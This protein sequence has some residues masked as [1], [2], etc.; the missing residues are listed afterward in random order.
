MALVD[1][2][3]YVDSV[4]WSAVTAW[5]A[6][7]TYDAGTLR[8][9]LAAPAV[10]SERIFV[11]VVGHVASGAAEPTWVI[12]RGGKTTD[13]TITW[14]EATGIAALNGDFSANTPTWATV[15]NTVVTLGQVI[16]DVA[17]SIVL[18]CTTAGTA[19]NGAEPTWAAYTTAG[20][21]TAD[22]TVTWTNIG[23]VGNFTG[24]QAPHARLASAFAATWG[25]V[26]NT[27]FV[28][29]EHAETRTT[30]MTLTS[31]GI[32]TNP[33]FV[34]CVAKT[35]I[36]P[37]AATTGATINTTGASNITFGAQALYAVGVT[38]SA[39][40]V[41]S[42]ASII[43][44]SADQ[45]Y[46]SFKTCGL[47][48]NNTSA[49]SR[50]YL[51][52][53]SFLAA[54]RFYFDACTFTFGSN[55]GQQ[56][57]ADQPLNDL[58]IRGG[59]VVVGANVPTTLFNG[60]ATN[61]LLEG[62]DLSA[63][64]SG[65]T[66]IGASIN[67]GHFEIKDCK[68]ATGVT[69]S[70]APLITQFNYLIRADDTGT[71]YRHELR[72]YP[73]TQTVDTTIVRTGGA[74]DGTTPISWKIITTANSKWVL[75]FESYPISLW[76]DAVAGPVTVTIYGTTT[77]GGVP[78]DD[79]IWMEIECLGTSGNPLGVF[80]TTTK[81]SVLVASSA[82]NNSADASTWGGGGAGNGFKI[83]GT[84]TPVLKGP[85]TVYVKAALASTTYYIDPRPAIS[86]VT[87]SKSEIL[88][89]GVYTNELSSQGP[90]GQQ[91][92]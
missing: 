90:V 10:G 13:A 65:K 36:P 24:W 58:V 88:A 26:G 57:L 83:V 32:F 60:S 54:S 34:V 41:A 73:G 9:Q 18:I 62:F 19:G 55:T 40:S 42:T 70:A 81:A 52:N 27:F 47:K 82:V 28:A 8:R 45:T 48:L 69:I 86:G 53:N 33:C 85:I 61:V 68:L 49:S 2:A 31:P 91:C 89:P 64:P 78:N 66:L 75:P 23:V 16:N 38:I 1:N 46:L 14:Q 71:N 25:Q 17:R 6:L 39:G 43:Y 5:A 29:S 77:G 87:V 72:A 79:A 74:T 22:N 12:T 3:W 44:C 63:I 15:K 50:H 76:S 7:T 20:A 51:N 59:S 21:T 4:G 11:V 84:F 67:S 92:M 56:F 37:T 80:T 30:A 35:P